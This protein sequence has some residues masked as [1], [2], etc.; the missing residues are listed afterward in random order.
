MIYI[1]FKTHGMFE[2]KP[3]SPLENKMMVE[4]I[5]AAAFVMEKLTKSSFSG[6]SAERLWRG[7]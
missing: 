4:K 2:F 7:I 5:V 6:Q 3:S 1:C